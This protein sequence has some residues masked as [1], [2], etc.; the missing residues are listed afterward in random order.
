LTKTL[1]PIRKEPPPSRIDV[2]THYFSH[3]THFRVY[4]YCKK[5]VRFEDLSGDE[6]RSEFKA[7]AKKYNKG[8]LEEVFYRDDIPLDLVESCQRTRFDWGLQPRSLQEQGLLDTVQA[9]VRATTDARGEPPSVPA[10]R[11]TT[12]E[13]RIERAADRRL[14]E[15]VR[16]TNEEL[17]GGRKEGRERLLEK[18]R[19]KAAIQHGSARDREEAAAGAEMD[20]SDLYGGGEDDFRRALAREKRREEERQDKKRKRVQ[21]LHKKEEEK[22]ENMFKMLGLANLPPG[23]KITIQPRND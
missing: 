13:A 10:K 11:K 22:K 21:E 1:G 17:E 19:E 12:E 14:R 8:D 23:H 16:A 20:D 9:Q 2:S 4:L 7:F 18:R 15:Q 3:H 6:A 5:S